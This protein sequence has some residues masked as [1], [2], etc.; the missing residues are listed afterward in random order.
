MVPGECVKVQLVSG[1]RFLVNIE[2][3]GSVEQNLATFSIRNLIQ[4][5]L[6]VPRSE[7]QINDGAQPVDKS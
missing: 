4:N 2:A 3:L 1:H 6:V 5:F 7:E